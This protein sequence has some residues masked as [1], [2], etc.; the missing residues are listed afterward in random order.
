MG[1]YGQCEHCGVDLPAPSPRARSVQRFCK[2]A[3]RSAWH[4]ERH[5]RTVQ[6]VRDIV[7]DAHGAVSAARDELDR[8]AARLAAAQSRLAPLSTAKVRTRPDNKT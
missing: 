6:L 7:D 8:V 2:A 1:E 5:R 3:H 4:L